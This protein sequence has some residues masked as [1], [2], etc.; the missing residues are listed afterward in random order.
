MNEIAKIEEN[1]AVAVD[2]IMASIEKLATSKD[3]NPEVLGMLFDRLDGQQKWEAERA[4]NAAMAECQAKLE[5]VRRTAF[6]DQT[7]SKYAKLEHISKMADPIISEHGFALSFGAAPTEDKNYLHVTCDVT[8]K[9]GHARRY[10]GSYPLDI[11]GIKGTQNKTAIHAMGSTKTY[12]RR[13][14]KMDIFDIQLENDDDA[15]SAVSTTISEEQ[16]DHLRKKLDDAEVDLGAFCQHFRIDAYP[17]L[18]VADWDRALAMI[19]KKK[20][21]SNG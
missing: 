15:Q 20:E 12:A 17:S 1:G 9:D 2:P 14:M 3:V 16:A 10:E 13:Y 8:H 4:Y 5:P 21:A 19:A 7:K 18:R 6:N 11:A